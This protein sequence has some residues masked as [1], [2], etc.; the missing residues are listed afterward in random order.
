MAD[1]KQLYIFI[2]LSALSGRRMP[3]GKNQFVNTSPGGRF[4]N[5]PESDVKDLE[6]LAFIPVGWYDASAMDGPSG[7]LY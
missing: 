1:A 2:G 3:S 4:Y 5:V 6:G 7:P